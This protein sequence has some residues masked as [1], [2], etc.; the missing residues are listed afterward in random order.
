MATDRFSFEGFLPAKGGERARRLKA[1]ADDERT[2]VL[3]EAPHRVRR[4]IADLAAACGDS[5]R[6]AVARELTKV[7]EEVWRGTLAGAA[8]HLEATEPRGEYALVVEGRA[9]EVVVADE[10]SISAALTVHL[11]AG[12]TKRD[13]VANVARELGVPKRQVYEVVLGL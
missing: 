1:V 6:V 4:T 12:E 13:A 7:H 3:Y 5:R 10:A 9:P 2:V 8:I 11:H